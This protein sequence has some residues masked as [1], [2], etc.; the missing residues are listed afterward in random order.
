MAL[1]G[2]TDLKSDVELLDVSSQGG[3]CT[4]PADLPDGKDL[5]LGAVGDFIDG[6]AT[7]CGGKNGGK[8]C[9]GYKFEIQSWLK[10]PFLMIVEREEAAGIKM[11]NGSWLIIGGRTKTGEAFANSEVLVNQGFHPGLIW[12]QHIWGHCSVLINSTHG[13]IAGGRNAINFIR[14]SYVLEFESGFWTW[15]ADIGFE[16]S[17]H[18]CGMINSM[19]EQFIIVAGG[20]GLLE[21]ELLSLSI[22]KF[23]IGP[24]LPHEMDQAASLQIDDDFIIIGGLHSAECPVKLTECFSSRYIYRLNNFTEW[25]RI[26]TEMSTRRGRHVAIAIPREIL[27]VACSKLCSTCPGCSLYFALF[28]HST[29]L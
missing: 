8:E 25:D 15:V 22:G 10:L 23:R 17:G 7:V 28:L 14:T 26:D 5:S 24:E 3:I 20:Q 4:K 11:H 9:H 13:F 12:P 2:N 27:G 29:L 1:G 6:M 18:V 19:N 21:V 16:R